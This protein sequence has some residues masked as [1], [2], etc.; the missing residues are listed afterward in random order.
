MSYWKGLGVAVAIDLIW[1]MGCPLLATE[2]PPETRREPVQQVAA[3][4][5]IGQLEDSLMERLQ[6]QPND[7]D[8]MQKLA[9]VY[10]SNGWYEA[11]IGPLARAL[12]L[13]PTRRSLWS[14][15]DTAIAKSGRAKMTDKELTE[16]AAAFVEAV[17]MWGH[18]C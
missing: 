11:A 18:G 14:A 2:P 12:Q 9:D 1:I 16:K 17:E 13:D 3:L 10:A 7:I 6:D 5:A 15:L 8:A 4:A